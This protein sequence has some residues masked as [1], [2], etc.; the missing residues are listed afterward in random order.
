MKAFLLAAGFGERLRPITGVMP[1]PLAPVLNVPAICYALTLLKRAG[2]T[3]VVCNLHHFYRQVTDFFG[4]NGNFGMDIHFSIEERLL[5]TGGGLMKCRALLDDGPFFYINSDVIADIDLEAF[6]AAHQSS[7]ACASMAVAPADRGAG[8]VTVCNGGVVNLRSL[9][10]RE[11]EPG[12][13]FI[14]VALLTPSIFNHLTSGV[15]DIVE[16]GLIALAG[17]SSIAAYAYPETWY[18]IG[19]TESYRRA[20]VGMIGADWGVI[21]GMVGATGLS[22]SAISPGAIIGKGAAIERSV[23]GDGCRVGEGAVVEESVLF[24]GAVVGSGESAVRGVFLP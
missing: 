13:D 9:L 8:R 14:G 12:H 19:T 3:K 11:D 1:K 20:N 2:V 22:T 15:S 21:K 16:T 17:M 6:R 23:I 24:P 4:A 18:D 10:P 5:G 7:G